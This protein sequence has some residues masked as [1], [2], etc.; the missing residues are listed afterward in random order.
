MRIAIPSDDGTCI[1]AHT[2]RA[3]G[4]II[5][6][7]NNGQV[8]RLE[9]R[10]NSYTAYARGEC[11][12]DNQGQPHHHHGHESL[13]DALHDCQI[14][15]SRGMGPR[16]VA[17]LANRG[18]QVIFCDRDAAEEAAKLCAQGVLKSTGQSCCSH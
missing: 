12:Q 18:M 15:I 1:A 2:G 9:Y 4:F 14:M 7:I 10:T 3:G 13:L 5:F 17:D 6:E 11:N 8:Q 16:L